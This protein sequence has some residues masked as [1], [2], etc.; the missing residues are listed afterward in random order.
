MVFKDGTLIYC[1]VKGLIHN[2]AVRS[3]FFLREAN[4][5]AL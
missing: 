3:L 2:G 4:G 1:A 5:R